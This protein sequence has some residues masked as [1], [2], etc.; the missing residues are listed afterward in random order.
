M[1]IRSFQ[2]TRTC[3]VSQKLATCPSSLVPLTL[4]RVPARSQLSRDMRQALAC[5]CAAYTVLISTPPHIALNNQ[6]SQSIPNRWKCACRDLFLFKYLDK[7]MIQ[8]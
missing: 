2:R 1:N 8:L 3:S 6:V 4:N 5:L 7:R